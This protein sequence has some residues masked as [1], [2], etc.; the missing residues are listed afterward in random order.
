M[1]ICES[2]SWATGVYG[3][4]KRNVYEDGTRTCFINYVLLLAPLLFL[5]VQP[6]FRPLLHW[7]NKHTLNFL[8]LLLSAFSLWCQEKFLCS[9]SASS[10][11]SD[12]IGLCSLMFIS[13]TMKS[14]L[15]GGW[16]WLKPW[17]NPAA[18]S[19]CLYLLFCHFYCLLFCF[20]QHDSALGCWG[21]CI[22]P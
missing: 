6:P 3:I 16:Q 19:S 18:C 21:F 10:P 13:T 7:T 12:S 8:N 5:S 20:S 15:R 9:V 22:R 4:F 2:I 14:P 17:L 1:N 11:P